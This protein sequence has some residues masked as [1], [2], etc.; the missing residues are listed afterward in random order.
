MSDLHLWNNQSIVREYSRLAYNY[1]NKWSFYIQATTQ[2]TLNRFKLQSIDRVLDIGCG[3]GILLKQLASTYPQSRLF[4]VDPVPKMLEVARQR[5]PETIDLAQ[6]WAEKLL[7]ED[8]QFDVAISCNMFHYIRQP[9]IALQEMRRVL[10]MGGKLIITD[11]CDDYWTC[12]LCDIFLRRFD[13]AHFK[14]YRQQEF[15]QILED[16]GYKDVYIERY[17]INWLWGLMTATMVK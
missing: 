8:E 9:M 14:T 13:R 15:R 17:K 5:L 3:T 2:E 12:H 4:G 11:W 1:D 10:R 7:F 6:G 16:A